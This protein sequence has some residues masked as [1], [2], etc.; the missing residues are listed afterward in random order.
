[1][2][3]II[4]LLALLGA[5]FGPSLWV[6]RVMARY[7]EPTDRYPLTGGELARDLLHGLRLGDITVETTESGDHY[8]PDAGA[9]RLSPQHYSGRSL[10]AVTI[11][12]HE[13]GHAVQHAAGYGPLLW[14]QRLVK[15]TRRTQQLGAGM[16]MAMPVV[17]G[18]TRAPG[19]ALLM[20]LG[21]LLSV[22]SGALVHLVTLP[23]EWDASFGRAMPL[24]ERSGHLRR[25]DRF[26]ARRIL[27]A[28]AL[29]YVAQSLASLLNVWTWFRMLRPG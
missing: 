13:V 5:I 1:M 23:T 26:H 6:R 24:L 15:A 8:D 19:V 21:G 25:G 2:A 22:G 3:Y 16:L 29:T 10:T 17:A 18:M 20:V 27:T 14:R 7:S 11:A 12:A 9:V 4:L 28:A